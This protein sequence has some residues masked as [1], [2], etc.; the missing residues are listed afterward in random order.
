MKSLMG[1]ERRKNKVLIHNCVWDFCFAVEYCIMFKYDLIHFKIR[2]IY[3]LTIWL[4]IFYHE[5]C[6]PL[7]CDLCCSKHPEQIKALWKKNKNILPM[8]S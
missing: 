6:F 5:E 7:P 3:L 1:K 2:F 4:E 8:N